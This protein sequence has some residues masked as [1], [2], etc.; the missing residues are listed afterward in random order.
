MEDR[1]KQ[2]AEKIAV[3]EKSLNRVLTEVEL[4]AFEHRHDIKLPEGY[5][6]FLLEIGNGGDGPPYYNLVPLGQG[7]NSSSENEVKYWQQLPNIHLPFPFTML[8]VWE[9][10][11]ESVE[12]TP[13]QARHGNIFLGEDGCGMDWVLIVNGAERGNVWMVSGVGVAPTV[14]KRDFLTWYENWLD[15]VTNWLE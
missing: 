10:G 7:P 5:R 12:G 2:I 14:P 8:F 3:A 4:C 1:L 11:G 9:G 15:G 6:R 13:A